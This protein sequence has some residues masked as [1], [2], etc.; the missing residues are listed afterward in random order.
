MERD[1]HG[2]SALLQAILTLWHLPDFQTLV[3]V[4][5][6]QPPPDLSGLAPLVV[7]QAVAGD[8]VA[9]RVLHAE[10]GELAQLA[11]IILTRVIASGAPEPPPR[12]AF[13]GSIMQHVALVR[14]T[15][16]AL[17]ECDFPRLD[18]LPGVV[19][20]VLGALWRARQLT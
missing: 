4:A 16:V 14:E 19:D 12:L 15:I 8:P 18:P 2:E 7:A 17:L 20:P 3:D 1:E 9:R 13:A 6:R 11:R 5:N 10:A